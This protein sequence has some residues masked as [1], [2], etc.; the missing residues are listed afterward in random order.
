MI[1]RSHLLLSVAFICL[2][3]SPRPAIAADLNPAS[4]NSLASIDL[5]T[6]L[7][8]AGAQ[9]LDVQIARERLNEAKANRSSAV[10][11]F[12][13]WFSPGIAYHRRDGMAQGV[14]AG[15]VSETHLESY[16][17]GG[18]IVGQLNLGDAIYQSLAAKQL[19]EASRQALETQRLD[20]TLTAAQGYFDLVKAK[21]LADVVKDAASISESY[22]QQLHRAVETGIAFKGDEL[23]VQ[24]Q[25]QNY[26]I[27]LRQALEQQRAESAKLAQLLHLDATVELLPQ[28]GDLAPLVLIPSDAALDSLVQQ[29]LRSSPELKQSQASTRA[30][31]AAKNGAVY[32]PLIPSVGAQVFV[33]G[34][35]G[36]HDNGPG[37]F[38]DAQDYG[39]GLGWRIGPGGLFDSGRVNASKARLQAVELSDVKLKDVIIAS[40]VTRHNRVQSLLEQMALAERKLATGNQT[41]QLTRDRKQFGVGIVLEDIQ[42][43]QELTKARSDYLSAVAEFNKAQYALS[44]AMGTIAISVKTK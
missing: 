18:T 26:Q 31:R 36:G 32:G 19:V 39:V 41:L 40:V 33:G 27:A 9:S 42:A 38:G 4:I 2:P 7:R 44:R 12:F 21:A 30:A 23:R 17:P 10:E 28:N 34:F 37:N 3:A 5:P 6:V 15:T 43:Q 13:P 1:S 11:Q 14:P 29:A 20:S 24:T 25:T 35:G 16:A 8:L 22:Q